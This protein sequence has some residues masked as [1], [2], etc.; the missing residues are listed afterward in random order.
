MKSPAIVIICASLLC[1]CTDPLSGAWQ[2]H[3]PDIVGDLELF[4]SDDLTGT[5]DFAIREAGGSLERIQA[6]VEASLIDRNDGV[7]TYQLLVAGHDDLECD[8]DRP[9]DDLECEFR[10]ADLEFEEFE[11]DASSCKDVCTLGPPRRSV[12]SACT[13]AVC[14]ADSFCCDHAWDMTC[15]N[16]MVTVCPGGPI[17]N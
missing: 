2:S 14:Q 1:A 6:N 17:C 15:R 9:T 16:L 13:S 3:G 7:W 4:L 11:E 10:V 12:C 8:L 5:L